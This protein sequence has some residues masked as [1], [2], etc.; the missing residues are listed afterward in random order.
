[1]NNL[2]LG[3]KGGTFDTV[4]SI[5]VIHH[6]S[7]TEARIECLKEIK[8]VLKVKG[9]CLVYVWAFEQ[10]GRQFGT[11]DQFV[12][13]R[14][15]NKYKGGSNA[16][17]TQ[18]TRKGVEVL[19]RYYHLFVRNELEEL[20]QRVGGL[21]VVRSFYDHQNWCLVFQKVEI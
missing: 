8:R 2:K 1:M 15:Q 6:L 17:P 13:W 3:F 18:D 9:E 16:D 19:K 10:E 20:V 14:L 12:Q 7:K 4:I 21:E 11:Q 5:A